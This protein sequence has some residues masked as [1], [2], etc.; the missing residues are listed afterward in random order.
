MSLPPH[1]LQ[2]RQELPAFLHLRDGLALFRKRSRGAYVDAFPAA[3]ACLGWS[4]GL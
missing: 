4:P 2:V 1:E 3:G